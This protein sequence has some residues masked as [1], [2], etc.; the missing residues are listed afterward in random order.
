MMTAK[1]GGER[2]VRIG[3]RVETV[4]ENGMKGDIKASCTRGVLTS[5][6]D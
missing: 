2:Q 1:L 5:S 6:R 4:G 3:Y